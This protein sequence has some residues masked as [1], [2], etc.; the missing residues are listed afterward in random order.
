MASY[1][2]FVI[3]QD[4][5]LIFYLEFVDCFSVCSATDCSPPQDVHFLAQPATQKS[6]SA[7]ILEVIQRRSCHDASP[8][9]EAVSEV[10]CN[11]PCRLRHGGA[12]SSG[13]HSSSAS[14]H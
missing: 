12:G 6:F 14:C 5:M 13:G 8:V 4:E 3:S 10:D 9:R 1:F 2:G 7:S 11:V